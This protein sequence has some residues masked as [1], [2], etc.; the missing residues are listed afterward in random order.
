MEQVL[1]FGETVR[2]PDIRMLYDMQEVVYD[3]EWLQSTENFELYYM[4]RE[5]ARQASD[6]KLMEAAGLR[7]DI[8][9]IPPAHLGREFI[10]T[11][12]HYHPKAPGAEVSYPEIYQVLEGEATYLLQ[13]AE[14][15]KVLDVV[16]VEAKAGEA[17]IIPPD[18]GH[19]S[20]N[21]ADE[22]LK[23]ANWVCT[24]F[25][26][27]YGPVRQFNGGAYYLLDEGFVPNSSYS[28]IPEIR[29]FSPANLSELGIFKGEDMY[30]LVNEIEILRF[31]TEPQEFT[32][33]FDKVF[34]E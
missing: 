7:Y 12:G 27:V 1:Q 8:T 13:K 28:E 20:I 32:E 21:R 15:S 9:V 31:L 30:E 4:Y 23:M 24:R 26:S 10:K 2:V 18:Y 11:A 22:T 5:L 33:L 29:Q 17:V 6:L 3:R 34:T 25:S 16:V 14:G 19:M